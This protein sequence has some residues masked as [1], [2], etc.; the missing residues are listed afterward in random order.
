MAS[1]F[2]RATTL[3][4]CRVTTASHLE[5]LWGHLLVVELRTQH[6]CSIHH[7]R[8]PPSH[9]SW[10]CYEHAVICITSN[11]CYVS[12]VRRERG[13]DTAVPNAHWL[14][15]FARLRR[16]R[17]TDFYKEIRDFLPRRIFRRHAR[18]A[19][20][21]EHRIPTWHGVISVCTVYHDGSTP[22]QSFY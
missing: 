15:T 12:S 1:L 22:C 16:G 5:C 17:S 10:H 8:R 9:I 21:T 20:F 11:E 14:L 7:P 6:S 13:W 3:V 18:C 19:E 4:V 2:L